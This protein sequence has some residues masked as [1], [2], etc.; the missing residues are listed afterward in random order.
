MRITDSEEKKKKGVRALGRLEKELADATKDL[1][2]QAVTSKMIVTVLAMVVM[3]SVQKRCEAVRSG[4]AF[5]LC[6]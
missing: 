1:Q 6:F 3:I 5:F 4:F 2:A